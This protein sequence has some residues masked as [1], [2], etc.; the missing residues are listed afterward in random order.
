MAKR[1]RLLLAGAERTVILDQAGGE[2]AQMLATIDDQ[3]PQAI[4]L[5]S[6]ELPGFVSFRAGGVTRRAYVARDGAAFEVTVGS[7]RFLVEQTTG[8]GRGRGVVGGAEDAPG[9]ITA[10]LAGVVVELRVEAGDALEAGTTVLV[11]EAMKMQ[12]EVQIPRDGTITAVHVSA[13]D[14]VEKGA[15]LVEYD[16]A[17]DRDQ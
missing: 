9:E 6:A 5:L 17:E 4:E 12:N 3:E 1:H 14:N 13:R 2:P 7:R 16:P 10:P 11:L 15:L 8:S